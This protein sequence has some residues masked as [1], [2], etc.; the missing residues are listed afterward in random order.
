MLWG[1]RVYIGFR[2]LSS[3]VYMYV[4]DL[5]TQNVQRIILYIGDRHSTGGVRPLQPPPPPQKI[6]RLG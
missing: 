2:E 1:L 4:E 3:R 5:Y 6:P